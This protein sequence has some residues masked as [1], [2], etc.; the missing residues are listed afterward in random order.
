MLC[1]ICGFGL[2]QYWRDI[3]KLHF[4]DPWENVSDIHL[5][6]ESQPFKKRKIPSTIAVSVMPPVQDESAGG[7]QDMDLEDA[8]ADQTAFVEAETGADLAPSTSTAKR[9]Q[10]T[11]GTPIKERPPTPGI[12]PEHQGLAALLVQSMESVRSTLRENEGESKRVE[13]ESRRCHEGMVQ[14]NHQ[15]EH[16]CAITT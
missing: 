5:Y 3:H 2:A 11:D 6:G 8:A 14:T 9:P 16:V 10:S 4:E 15:I 7:N 1:F 13:E 12:P